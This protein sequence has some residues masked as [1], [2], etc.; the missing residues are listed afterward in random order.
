MPFVRALLPC[1]VAATFGCSTTHHLG[2][3]SEAAT[4]AALTDAARQPGAYV[5]VDPLPGDRYGGPWSG[6]RIRDVDDDGVWLASPGPPIVIVPFARV[7]SITT[8]DHAEGARVGALV[9]GI[10]GFVLLGTVGAYFARQDEIAA[11]DGGGGP[12]SPAFVVVVAA[13]GGLV[14]GLIGAGLGG[15]AGYEDRYVVAP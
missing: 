4:V 8:R 9:G 12:D 1:V 7:R 11:R 5:Q 2:R 3:A 10:A 14:G 15:V 13:L 6:Y